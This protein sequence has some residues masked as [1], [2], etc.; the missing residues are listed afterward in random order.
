MMHHGPRGEVRRARIE[1]PAPD[2]RGR[3]RGYTRDAGEG[4]VRAHCTTMKQ[5]IAFPAIANR[6]NRVAMAWAKTKRLRP[7][8]GEWGRKGGRS[9][10]AATGQDTTV[11]NR[12]LTRN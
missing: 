10:R 8:G 1:T 11:R 3:S 7:P 2:R 4:D 5:D 6:V 12:T 9:L